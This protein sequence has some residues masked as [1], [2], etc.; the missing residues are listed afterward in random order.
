MKWNRN[1][2]DNLPPEGLRILVSNGEITTIAY[3]IN[4]DNHKNWFYENPSYKDIKVEWW[5]ILPDN[6]PK[7]ETDIQTYEH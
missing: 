6:P 2:V 4:S 5:M 3:Y 1:I 7:I